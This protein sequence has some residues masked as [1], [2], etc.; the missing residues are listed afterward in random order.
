MDCHGKQAVPENG[1]VDGS[2]GGR[3]VKGQGSLAGDLHFGSSDVFLLKEKLPVEVAD[4][5]GVQINLDK[6]REVGDVKSPES[7]IQLTV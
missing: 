5:N 6:E 7:C 2:D 4:F 3:G 1:V